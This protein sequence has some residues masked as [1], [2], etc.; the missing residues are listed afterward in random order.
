MREIIDSHNPKKVHAAAAWD[1]P[2]PLVF[3]AVTLSLSAFRLILG[4][5]NPRFM[6]KS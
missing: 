1:D 6:S 3:Q 5:L 4:K 2:L